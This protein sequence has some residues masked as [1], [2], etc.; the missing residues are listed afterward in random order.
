MVRLVRLWLETQK[1]CVR[2]RTGSNIVI[3]VVQIQCLKL[4]KGLECAVVSIVLCT[5]NKPWSYS[6]TERHSH[7]FFALCKTTFTLI[8]HNSSVA[9]GDTAIPANTK[10]SANAGTMLSHRLRRWPDIIPALGEHLAFAGI[11]A[12]E[13]CVNLN[14][15]PENIR[16][17]SSMS[18]WIFAVQL[19]CYI[20]FWSVCC[21]MS[22]GGPI[23]QEAFTNI[24]L[25]LRRRRRWWPSVTPTMAVRILFTGVDLG[26][27]GFHS[28]RAQVATHSVNE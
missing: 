5:I 2:I 25:M 1:F 4:F 19:V 21:T 13:V 17:T 16:L 9:G 8:P 3:A 7:N 10:H 26:S 14:S 22:R 15:C 6:I 27:I 28:W 23:K 12:V 11:E 24:G 20:E 18:I